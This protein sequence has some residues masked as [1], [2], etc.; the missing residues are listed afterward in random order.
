[1]KN[2][3]KNISIAKQT[4]GCKISFYYKVNYSYKKIKFVKVTYNNMTN[5]DDQKIINLDL[6]V[7][8]SMS[9]KDTYIK[10]LSCEEY[11]KEVNTIYAETET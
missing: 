11:N 1:M 3:L 7:R 9:G 6:A 2:N 5:L 10:S 8:S 4:V